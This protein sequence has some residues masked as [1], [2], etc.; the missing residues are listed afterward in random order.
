M[1]LTYEKELMNLV[2][3]LICDTSLNPASA[4][5]SLEKAIVQQIC[6]VTIK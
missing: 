1:D 5:E 6:V 4:I 2:V 3:N